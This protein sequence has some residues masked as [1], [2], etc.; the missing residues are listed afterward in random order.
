[1]SDRFEY[2]FKPL[3]IGAITV[4]KRIFMSGAAM[5]YYPGNGVLD[6]WSLAFWETRAW[7]APKYPV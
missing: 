1:M 2:L 3:K 7:G 4:R 6:D 5:R